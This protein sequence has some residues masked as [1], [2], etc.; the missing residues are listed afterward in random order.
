MT[1]VLTPAVLRPLLEEL[2]RR[3]P[4]EHL[5]GVQIT[6]AWSGDAVVHVG[7]EARPVRVCPST[8]DVRA[9]AVEQEALGRPLVVLTPIK[10]RELGL[11]L[12]ARF[13]GQQ[14]LQPVVARAVM[15]LF[16]AH[17]LDRR[18]AREEWLLRALAEHLPPG[19]YA[20]VPSGSLTADRAWE[21]LLH[22]T[23][24][25][26][27]A[28]PTLLELLRWAQVDDH[29]RR[30]R[31]ADP[32]LRAG[33]RARLAHQPGSELLLAIV[34][35]AGN[36]DDVMAIVGVLS[37][38]A[39][40]PTA[41]AALLASGRVAERHL[42]GMGLDL[43][44]SAHALVLSA[45]VVAREQ[46]Q[47][48]RTAGWARR[49]CEL[50]QGLDLGLM[51]EASDLLEEAWSLR[52]ARFAEA[53]VEAERHGGG[54]EALAA[55]QNAVGRHLRA[56]AEGSGELLEALESLARLV[57]W[58]GRPAAPV[59]TTLSGLIADEVADGGWVARAR[60]QI[61]ATGDLELS[62]AVDRVGRAVD[63][64]RA[65]HAS[66]FA[67]AAVRWDGAP[68]EGL[69]G[70]EHVLDAIVAPTAAA[71][72]TLVVVLDGM[73]LA[74][75]RELL[76]DLGPQGWL[77]RRPS[78][79]PTRPAA[80]AVLP[81]LTTLSRASLLSGR[82][83][84]GGQSAEAK[85]F[86]NHT[87]LRQAG[88]AGGP[89]RLFHK[90]A[91]SDDGTTLTGAVRDEIFGERRVVGAVVNAIDD[92]L[93]GAVQR[94]HRWTVRDIPLLDAVLEAARNAERAV[95]LLSDHGHVPERAGTAR[96]AAAG[97][98]IGDR[99]RPE[100]SGP[101]RAGEVLAA[102]PR[103]LSAGGR[104]VLAADPSIR[105]TAAS[106]P[107]YH[108][109]ASPEELVAPIA[110]LTA[111]D[112]PLDGLVDQAV[113]E[114]EWWRA[115]T[116]READAGPPPEPAPRGRR[117]APPPSPAQ[118]GLFAD[119]GPPAASPAPTPAWV[120]A[121]LVHPDFRQ[122]RERAGRGALA[123]DRTQAL[124]VALARHDGRLSSAALS[125]ASGVPQARLDGAL[126][127]LRPMLNVDGYPIL[128]VDTGAD[129]VELKISDLRRQFGL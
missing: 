109:G 92:E 74:V 76:D 45:M 36:A 70:V 69:L 26:P 124:L 62:G 100:A 82:L 39:A 33:L 83:D 122:A 1:A 129:L 118:G 11:D 15:Q 126:S 21:E 79:C 24:D 32:E 93:G 18:I 108:G 106:K 99:S 121:L 57:R 51:V 9:A 63:E 12:T 60:V 111:F 4:D 101:V 72:P 34:E 61:A 19:G 5:V 41:P 98:G 42:G 58:L 30:L 31:A 128:S 52:L 80:L 75:L 20:P 44:A 117:R 119:P 40:A 107:G 112:R 2:R 16:Q 71:A 46:Q 64:R 77:E 10:A 113:D 67:T 37:V 22:A 50:C 103:V 48:G 90:A 86:A 96:V 127:A 114:P 102:G 43:D 59:P 55:A 29:R 13:A 97:A 68:G 66:T 95:V 116:A 27:V 78:S 85:G 84:S 49:A 6:G 56:D 7:N 120:D 110:A 123:D 81:S 17:D 91:L 53:V 65:M 28:T 54:L 94:R 35:H 8:L 38:L 88:T 104:V 3:R 47:A 23:L 25:L 87:G 105:Y 115:E 125:S 73:S 14:L 89:P